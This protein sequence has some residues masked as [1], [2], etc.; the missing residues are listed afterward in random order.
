MGSGFFEKNIRPSILLLS[1]MLAFEERK[2]W[3]EFCEILCSGRKANGSSSKETWF[4][5][6]KVRASMRIT[7]R[8]GIDPRQG[9]KE[10]A[11]ILHFICNRS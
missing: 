2:H 7:E 5:L 3:K 9:G 6:F 4:F 8:A 10:V 11:V 1:R